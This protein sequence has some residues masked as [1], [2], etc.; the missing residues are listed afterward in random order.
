MSARYI[1]E[2]D[3]GVRVAPDEGQKLLGHPAA[4]KIQK[5]LKQESGSELGY[6]IKRVS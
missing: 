6:R 1:V 2:T 4:L 5:R 3:K